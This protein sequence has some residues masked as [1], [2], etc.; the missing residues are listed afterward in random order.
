MDEIVD[1]ITKTI[2]D[3]QDEY[4]AIQE[5]EEAE[6]RAIAEKAKEA[7][8]VAAAKYEAACVMLD[9]LCD[10]LVATGEDELL[11]EIHRVEISKVV[12]LVDS[13]IELTKSLIKL[14]DVRIKVMPFNFL[15]KWLG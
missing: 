12:E 10:Y 7:D 6:A 11:E 5:K 4:K 1:D 3:A 13:S 15:G 8:R 9:G 2:N 14:K